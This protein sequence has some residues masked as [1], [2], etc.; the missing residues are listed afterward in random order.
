[1]IVDKGSECCVCGELVNEA[2]AQ[3]SKE[4]FSG[5]VLCKGCQKLEKTQ[6]EEGIKDVVGKRIDTAKQLRS[7]IAGIF[8]RLNEEDKKGL[9]T[10]LFAGYKTKKLAGLTEEQLG[11][12]LVWLE[13]YVAKCSD[14]ANVRAQESGEKNEVVEGEVKTNTT[15][16]GAVGGPKMSITDS[17]IDTREPDVLDRMSDT[18]KKLTIEWDTIPDHVMRSK[19]ESATKYDVAPDDDGVTFLILRKDGTGAEHITAEDSCDCQDWL[20]RGTSLNPCVHMVCA[21]YRNANLKEKL[22]LLK[23]IVPATELATSTRQGKGGAVAR[24]R[25]APTHDDAMPLRLAEIGKIKI[26]GKS[27]EKRGGFYLP[28]KWNHFKIATLI[29]DEEGKLELDVA[30][31]EVIGNDCKVL[32]IVLCY[33][34]PAMNLQTFYSLPYVSREK[35]LGDGKTATCRRDKDS[36]PIEIDCKGRGCARFKSGDCHQY[37]RLSVI[38]QKANRMGGVYVLRTQSAHT[39]NNIISSM[40]FL[41]NSTG[42]ILAGIPLQMR[43]LPMTVVPRSVGKQITVYVINIEF[44]GTRDELLEA[45]MAESA[46]RTQLG[47]NMRAVEDADRAFI[48]SRESGEVIDMGQEGDNGAD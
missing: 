18:K 25:D 20:Y 42:G 14:D 28:Q 39:I 33:D 1:M 2:A 13:E 48:T 12:I 38:L 21:H 19:L 17:K 27:E 24:Q 29:R 10:W 44:A 31:N 6:V 32:D 30:M 5:R 22:A 7:K 11:E 26:G 40:R 36:K 23:V 16:V 41:G 15:K 4:D 3:K 35:C 34:D 46:R 43:L 47:M 8:A 9:K 37:G 45:A